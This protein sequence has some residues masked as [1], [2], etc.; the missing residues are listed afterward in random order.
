M[1][2][3]PEAQRLTRSAFEHGMQTRDAEMAWGRVLDD[4][5]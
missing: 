2:R 3:E 4:L 1:V 5:A